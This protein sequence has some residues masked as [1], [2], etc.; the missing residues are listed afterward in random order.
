MEADKLESILEK[1]LYPIEIKEEES[2]SKKNNPK[3]SSFKPSKF[4][5]YCELLRDNLKLKEENL[6]YKLLAEF[7][8]ALIHPGCEKK[9]IKILDNYLPK[10]LKTDYSLYK[11]NGWCQ[12]KAGFKPTKA[13][14]ISA[15]K[16]SFKKTI[17]L[18]N[19]ETFLY[20]YKTGEVLDGEDAE[21]LNLKSSGENTIDL[22]SNKK[23]ILIPIKNEEGKVQSILSVYNIDKIKSIVPLSQIIKSL[24]VAIKNYIIASNKLNIDSLTGAY[25]RDYVIN[26]LADS[27][28]EVD[29]LHHK[30][31]VTKKLRRGLDTPLPYEELYCIF[32]DIDKFKNINDKYGHENADL[33]LKTT[34]QNVRNIIR[35]EDVLGRYGGDEFF[36]PFRGDDKGALTVAKRIKNKVK[37]GYIIDNKEIKIT[38]SIGIAKYHPQKNTGSID[39]KVSNL[40]KKA[41]FAMYKSKENGGDRVTCFF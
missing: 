9:F 36:M 24:S 37:T 13:V 15:S 31:G 30:L 23:S 8:A 6:S 12:T 2:Q 33:I 38:A 5:S 26:T 10:L 19:S 21:R 34:I 3:I 39:V 16:K 1:I 18:N 17:M 20:C 40:I 11:I 14:R 4:P 29:Y 22:N 32:F 41:D 28:K 7:N 35:S 27:I 25:N